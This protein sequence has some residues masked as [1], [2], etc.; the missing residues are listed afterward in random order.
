MKTIWILLILLSV[1]VA[2]QRHSQ[3]PERKHMIQSDMVRIEGRTVNPFGIRGEAVR[4]DTFYLD[5]HLVTYEQ[6]NQ[7]IEA[8]GYVEPRYWSPEGIKFLN[9]YEF[10]VPS[11]YHEEYLNKS[12]LPVTGVSWYEAEAYS[13]WR[14]ARLPTAAEWTLACQGSNK[15][16]Y[17]WGNAFD[18]EAVDYRTRLAPYPTSSHEKNVSPVGVFDLVGNVWQ[19]CKDAYEGEDFR[20]SVSPTGT[21]P[22]P[23]KILRGGGWMSLRKHFESDYLYYDKPH[24]RR[25]TYGFRCAKDAE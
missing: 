5:K 1:T 8:G 14:N 7:F 2:C 25:A 16:R 22:D 19:W 18:F 12:E 15:Q 9:A 24:H 17:P 13:N 21:R 10:T 3:T 6:Y 23:Q 11:T 20:R 4:V